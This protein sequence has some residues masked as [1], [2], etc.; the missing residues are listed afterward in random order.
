MDRSQIYATVDF[1]RPGKQHGHL[2]VPYSYNLGGWANLLV[3]VTVVRNGDG[4]TVLVLA[5]NHGDEYEGQVA[6]LRLLQEL[7]PGQVNGRVIVVP[8]L[9]IEASK[10]CTRLWSTGANFNRSF[11]GSP[12]GPPNEQLADYLTRVL[13]P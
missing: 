5:G 2:C 9:S 3:P 13:F 7:D 10:G 6:A 4:P 8:V 11:P 1:D 12:D